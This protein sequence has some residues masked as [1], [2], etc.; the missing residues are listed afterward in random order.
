MAILKRG[1]RGGTPRRRGSESHKN[2]VSNRK[3]FDG[4]LEFV[5]QTPGF[6][7][8]GARGRHSPLPF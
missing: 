1:F 6:F 5:E 7:M 3:W 2:W 4:F 8:A